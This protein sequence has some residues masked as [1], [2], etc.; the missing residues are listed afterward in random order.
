L[1]TDKLIAAI[2]S[3]YPNSTYRKHL[4]YGEI[5]E[6]GRRQEP[7]A[8][9]RLCDLARNRPT[10]TSDERAKAVG[11]IVRAS[12]VALLGPYLDGMVREA[13]TSALDDVDPLVRG[14]A[15]RTIDVWPDDELRRFQS[16][17]IK[18]L[19]D[20][21]RSVRTEAARVL[22][23]VPPGADA[24]QENRELFQRVFAEWVAGQ[25][26]TADQPGTH[27]GLGTAYANLLK[28]TE[29]MSYAA[30][31]ETEFKRALVLDP[32]H[33]P[34]MRNYAA[35]LDLVDRNAEAEA[36]LRRALELAPRV[37]EPEEARN[38]FLADTH[39]EIGWLLFRDPSGTRIAD[40]A[41]EFKAAL[42]GDPA[43]VQAWQ[44]Y[45]IALLGLNRFSEGEAALDRFCALA[46][47]GAA[48]MW[49]YAQRAA[50]S[51]QLDQARAFLAVLLRADPQAREHYA[52][53]SALERALSRP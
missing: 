9:A 43:N 32:I 38:R 7:H 49:T 44:Y 20:P 6:A 27:A 19:S 35:L 40:A 45:G 17:L 46:P 8:G 39:Y 37:D 15:V 21:I 12:A 33:L 5:F 36:L 23:R 18:T 52:G 31:A 11:P 30:Q 28:A 42:D 14:A 26:A 50:R 4:H 10:L 51:E 41:A 25:Q 48:A 13:I 53:L 22:T 24:V 29:E 2:E 34:T 47:H 1:S 16:Q 3:W